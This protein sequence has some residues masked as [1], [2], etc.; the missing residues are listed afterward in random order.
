MGLLNILC[1]KSG[2]DIFYKCVITEMISFIYHEIDDEVNDSDND[3][4]ND[5]LYDLEFIYNICI[6]SKY[7]EIP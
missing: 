5:D 1:L 3:Q 4:Q 6:Y 2:Y 7:Q